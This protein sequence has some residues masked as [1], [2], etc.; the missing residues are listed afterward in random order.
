MM[1]ILR[2]MIKEYLKVLDNINKNKNWYVM[3][4]IFLKIVYYSFDL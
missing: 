4:F 1:Y 2:F 3:V